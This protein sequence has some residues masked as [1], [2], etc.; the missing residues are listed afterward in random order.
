MNETEKKYTNEGLLIVSESHT[1]P[2][3][4][5]DTRPCRSGWTRACFFCKYADFRTEEGKRRAEQM[6]RGA[7]LYSV[8]QNESNKESAPDQG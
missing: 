6:P 8:C 1:C 7:K 2:L 3:W 4:E 5:K